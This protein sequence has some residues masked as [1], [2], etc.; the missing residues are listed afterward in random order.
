MPEDKDEILCSNCD[1]WY[2]GKK[3]NSLCPRCG[4]KN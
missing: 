2:Y 3:G 1:T 4:G